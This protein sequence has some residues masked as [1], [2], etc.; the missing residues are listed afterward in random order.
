M[1]N[2]LKNELAKKLITRLDVRRN[3]SKAIEKLNK[4][5][6]KLVIPINGETTQILILMQI[7]ILK[8]LF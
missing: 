7:P 6:V 2:N 4:F 5:R 1:V 8:I 3:K